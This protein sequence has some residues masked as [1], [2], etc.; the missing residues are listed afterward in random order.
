MSATVLKRLQREYKRMLDNPTQEYMAYPLEDNSLEWH[1]TMLGP[2]DSPYSEG[3][4]HGRILIPANYPFAPP[5]VVLL[6][7]NGRFELEK[8]ICL[9][10]SSYH[11]ENWQSTW[12]VHTVLHALRQFMLTPGNNAIGAIE[13]PADVRRKMALESINFVCPT[14]K[15]K[16]AEHRQKLLA[17]P[18]ATDEPTSVPPTPATV[19]QTPQSRP[20]SVM[21]PSVVDTPDASNSNKAAG[22]SPS[23]I[24]IAATS[25]TQ[26][27]TNADESAEKARESCDVLDAAEND[28]KLNPIPLDDSNGNT[29]TP[30]TPGV[31]PTMAVSPKA[32]A[33]DV[34]ANLSNTASPASPHI[35][36]SS[37][38]TLLAQSGSPVIDCSVRDRLVAFY[39][40]HKEEKK[41]KHVDVILKKY[42]G[43]ETHMFAA[44]VK[45]YGAEPTAEERAKLLAVKP[46]VPPPPPIPPPPPVAVV[47][48]ARAVAPVIPPNH[49]PRVRMDNRAG[50]L[51]IIISLETIDRTL[52]FLAW[53]IFI[54]VAKKA[55]FDMPQAP[56][57]TYL[58]QLWE[59]IRAMLLA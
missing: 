35:N 11:P 4:Y 10:I 47:P 7:P 29:A 38:D 23:D 19:P 48:P 42:R 37:A 14:C 20:V 53:I 31:S 26:H 1:F 55:I 9:S 6:T 17:N 46:Q 30:A 27:T 13:Y 39:K 25:P 49:R 33:D 51:E 5:D 36:D 44:L 45:K 12:G 18:A 41:L 50:G 54:I 3:C 24:A 58:G 2:A 8:R 57:H 15:Q 59:S 40:H 28:N 32:K 43:E 21:L 22:S 52:Y 56:P 16:I 34:V